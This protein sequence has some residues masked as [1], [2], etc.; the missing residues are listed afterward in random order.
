MCEP[1]ILATIENLRS[2][3]PKSLIWK[4]LNFMKHTR[5]QLYLLWPSFLSCSYEEFSR[6]ITLG[7]IKC[8]LELSSDAQWLEALRNNHLGTRVHGHT[9]IGTGGRLLSSTLPD[10][11]SAMRPWVKLMLCYCQ[12]AK[13]SARIYRPYLQDNDDGDKSA[14]QIYTLLLQG[15][16]VEFQ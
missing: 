1:V 10:Q 11:A 3:E 2:S 9:C 15:S 16:S 7:I 5:Y 4:T 12:V 14:I 8:Y 6:N 13:V